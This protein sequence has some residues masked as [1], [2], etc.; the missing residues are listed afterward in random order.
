ML[1]FLVSPLATPRVNLHALPIPLDTLLAQ[2][3]GVT[4]L[5]RPFDTLSRASLLR[6][7]A[8]ICLHA[9]RYASSCLRVVWVYRVHD[10]VRVCWSWGCAQAQ[11]P[12]RGPQLQ[13]VLP[14][15][16]FSVGSQRRAHVPQGIANRGDDRGTQEGA[17][18]RRR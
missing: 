15:L 5:A 17:V 11:Q 3:V 16:G 18:E 6:R 7:P 10:V 2:P 8:L 14:A 13:P 1:V 4:P 9:P 12:H